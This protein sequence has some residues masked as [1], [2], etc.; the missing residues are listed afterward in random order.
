MGDVG[1]TAL[2]FDLDDTLYKERDYVYS[3]FRWMGRALGD[4]GAADALRRAFEAGVGDPIGAMMAEKG[5]AADD[6][7]RLIAEMRDHAPDISLSQDAAALLAEMRAQNA[8]FSIVTN[9]RSGTQRRKIAALGLGDAASLAISEEVGAEKPDAKAFSAAA[10]V[11]AGA[12]LVYVGD[13][14]KKDFLAPKAMGWLTVMLR[15]D[16]RNVHRQVAPTP[17][18]A[19]AREI[20]ALTELLPLLE[21]EAV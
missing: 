11:H 2:V 1:R 14:P 15:D 21:R 8:A 3:C 17:A 12:K 18:H 19:A 4:A 10:A 13:N 6:R 20:D 9:G 16:G 7:T 5:V